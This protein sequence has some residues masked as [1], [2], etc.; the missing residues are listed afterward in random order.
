M[1]F[2]AEA[3]SFKSQT[4]H[5]PFS[6]LSDYGCMCH[7]GSSSGYNEEVPPADSGW[8]FRVKEKQ[9]LLVLKH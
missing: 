5:I 4:H 8:K 1:S 9:I 3:V 7:P 2:K 6:G